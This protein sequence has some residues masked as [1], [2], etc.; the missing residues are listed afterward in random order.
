MFKAK[1][2]ARIGAVAATVSSTL[3]GCKV[4]KGSSIKALGLVVKVILTILVNLVL[5]NKVGEVNRIARGLIPFVTL[6]CVILTLKIIILGFRGVP[7]MFKSVLRN[8]FSPTSIAK[9]TIKSFFVDVGGNISEKVFSGRTKL[10]ANSV[11]RTYTSAGGPMGRKFFKV[12]R[13]FISAVM[14][15]A[16]ATLI[17]LYDNIPIKCKR[18]TKT[19]LAVLKFASACKG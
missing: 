17:V 18:T 4:V 7:A 3:F 2:T 10:N 8:T 13:M 6:V 19:R 16:L 9:N 5:L 1:G 14:V 12:F 15:Y 11:T